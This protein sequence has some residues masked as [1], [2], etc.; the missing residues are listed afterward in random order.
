MGRGEDGLTVA[1]TISD[2]LSQRE[3]GTCSVLAQWENICI[4]SSSASWPWQA[5]EAKPAQHLL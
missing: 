1:N 2:I 5:L 4:A 3:S